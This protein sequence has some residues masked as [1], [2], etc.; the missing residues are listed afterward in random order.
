M[1]FI[2]MALGD[3]LY[4]LAFVYCWHYT[5]DGIHN[6]IWLSLLADLSNSFG[7]ALLIFAHAGIE[8][9]QGKR[10]ITK[11]KDNTIAAIY[12]LA[13]LIVIAFHMNWLST[14]APDYASHL[15]TIVMFIFFVLASILYVL[16]YYRLKDKDSE[17]DQL[18]RNNLEIRLL[19]DLDRMT[20]VLNRRAGL[21][22]AE[23][24]L[25]IAEM[26]N[27]CLTICFA[28]LD[29]LKETNDYFG[30]H[31]GDRL[32][33]KVSEVFQRNISKNDLIFRFGGDE[34]VIVF[35]DR[36]LEQAEKIWSR[37]SSEII[38]LGAEFD[39]VPRMSHGMVCIAPG[40][41]MEFNEAIRI[42]DEKM[43]RE[44]HTKKISS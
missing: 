30:H 25:E 20:G 19:A 44:K 33:I 35:F 5:L 28:D 7:V 15:V 32:L 12:V 13:T 41:K 16:S 26:E 14:I 11:T 2:G 21:E 4:G 17:L 3:M 6:S 27:K 31:E 36:I 10:D 43:Y 42:A 8:I 39:I 40:A 1:A 24:L 18:K 34:F 29:N 37:I 9:K 38:D 23:E 22:R